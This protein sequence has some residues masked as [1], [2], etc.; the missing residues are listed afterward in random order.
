MQTI[1]EGKAI[2]KVKETKKISKDMPVFYNPVM[3]LNRDIS[4]ILLNVIDKNN[5]IIADPLAGTGIRSI[6]FL[7]ELKKSK[8][9]SISINDYSKESIKSI[10]KNLSLNKIKKTNKIIIKNE[11]ANLFLLNSKGFDY[12]DIDPFGTPVPYLDSAIKRI[13]RDGILAVTATDTGCL[14][15]TFPKACIRKY[16]ATPKKSPIM[17]ETG[18]R[19]LIRK[20]QLIGA[21]YNKALTP[22]FSYSKEHYFRVFLKCEKGK[23]AADNILK[24]HNHFNNVGPMWLGNLWDSKLVKKMCEQS[25]LMDH[26]LLKMLKVIK[27]ESKI[28]NVGFH[29]IHKLCKKYKLK[30][31]KTEKLLKYGSRTIFNEYGIKTELTEKELV[32]IISKS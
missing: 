4:I 25:E 6:R 19:I 16:W 11:D 1:T 7:K 22:I 8:I 31:P 26:S 3:K 12:I 13:S 18:A 24:Q 17:H 23:E 5:L 14:C 32:K 28:N 9:K 30:I 10:K 29:D 27:N 2:I 21:Q 20:I 15:G